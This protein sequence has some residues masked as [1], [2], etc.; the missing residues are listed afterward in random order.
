MT[1]KEYEINIIELLIEKY[2][3]S[4]QFVTGVKSTRKIAIKLYYYGIADYPYYDIN[5]VYKKEAIHEAIMNLSHNGLVKFEWLKYQENHIMS[6]V[7]LIIENI[8]K[9]YDF[10][11]KTPKAENIEKILELIYDT[12]ENIKVKWIYDYLDHVFNEVTI[13]RSIC[14]LISEDFNKVNDLMIILKFIDKNDNNEILER[15]MSIKCFK[16][17]KYFEKHI[18]AKLT[19]IVKTFLFVNTE[20]DKEDVLRSI[21][22]VRYPELVEFCGNITISI[23]NKTVDYSNLIY[24]AT[25]N[26]YDI[27]NGVFEVSNIEKILFI[28]NKT[29]YFDYVMNK[30]T[31]K[32]LVI[33]HGG[34]YSPIKGIFF[35]KL[36]NSMDKSTHIL[37]WGDIDYGGFAMFEMLKS[38]IFNNAKTYRMGIKELQ[39]Y[40][41]YCIKIDD[42][43]IEKINNLKKKATLY[44][45]IDCLEYM[46]E[47]KIKLEQE[48]LLIE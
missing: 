32:E 25:L 35:E 41:K 14:N 6:R 12:K 30:K 11:N 22:V 47:N 34:F 31:N 36:K 42:A 10:I 46:I 8:D 15:V 3:R 28:E 20:E 23:N 38:N 37:H 39:E 1:T 40:E 19:T 43:Y 44:E 13:K 9:A 26:S 5:D 24:G 33:F 2:E 21:G 45:Y 7:W 18:K 48:A 16:N 27:K 17:S 29:N 4:R